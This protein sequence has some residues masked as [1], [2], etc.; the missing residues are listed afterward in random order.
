MSQTINTTL[1]DTT[2]SRLQK[3]A[4]RLGKTVSDVSAMLIE[5]SLRESDFTFIEFRNVSAERM[6]YM[7]NSRLSVWFVVMTA[8]E[9]G[10]DIEKTALH[11]KRPLLWVEDALKYAQ[12]YPNEIESEIEN[13]QKTN[14][15]SLQKLLPQLS[16]VN[17]PASVLNEH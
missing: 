14:V 17:I 13:Y 2:A 3:M 15:E 1:T 5:E 16:V 11:F 9:Y 8:K 4:H 7:K 12:A 6:A 10:M